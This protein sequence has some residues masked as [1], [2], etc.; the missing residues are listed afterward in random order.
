MQSEFVNALFAWVA[1][2]PG[3]MSTVIFITAMAESLTIVGVI[4]PGALV[5]FSLGALIGL[6]HLEFWTAYWWSTWGA[7]AGDAISFWIGRVFHQGIRQIW[8]FTKHPEMITRSEEFF[9]KHGGK[10]VL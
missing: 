4:I 3:W 10:G 2:H 5:M 7:I 1:A 8:P 6:G 9:R